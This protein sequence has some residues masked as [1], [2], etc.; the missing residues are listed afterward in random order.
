MTQAQLDHAVAVA[1]VATVATVH[2]RGFSFLPAD[3]GES[4]I[5]AWRLVVACPHCR[6]AV[7]Y[8]GRARDGASILAE[9]LH[10]DVYYD[11]DPAT[12]TLAIPPEA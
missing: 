4:E 2:R 12:V 8:P 3:P 11:A 10:C 5:E 1:T 9:C 7:D 6:R